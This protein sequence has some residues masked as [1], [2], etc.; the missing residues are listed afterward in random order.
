MSAGDLNVMASADLM[1]L[2]RDASQRLALRNYAADELN[3]RD[4]LIPHISMGTLI[5]YADH[6]L[7]ISAASSG[8]QGDP[9]T[10][11]YMA[12]ESAA[13]EPLTLNERASGRAADSS[14][15]QS[16]DHSIA[17]LMELGAS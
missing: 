12:H 2:L 5:P 13:A 6:R 17:Q 7:I 11:G 15:A 14:I 8:A 1:R 3:L 9:A 16:P 4:R 10:A